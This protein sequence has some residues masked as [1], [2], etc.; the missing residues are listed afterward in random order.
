[1]APLTARRARIPGISRRLI[2][3]VPS[4]MRFRVRRDIR[5]RRDSRGHIRCRRVNLDVLVEHEVEHLA[6]G[7]LRDGGLNRVLPRD[8]ERDG[9][10]GG[11]VRSCR[12]A[13]VNHP[14]GPVDGA[15]DG[16]RGDDHFTELV[17]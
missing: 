16:M 8:R 17:P 12:N 10:I 3:F 1:M 14:R 11:G 5:V 6:A 2:S 7:N 9:L 13:R 15:F 4:K